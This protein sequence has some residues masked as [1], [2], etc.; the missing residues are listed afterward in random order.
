MTLGPAFDE[1][2]RQINKE[3]AFAGST[4]EQKIANDVAAADALV[5]LSREFGE[6]LAAE[7]APDLTPAQQEAIY[8]HVWCNDTGDS[9]TEL[10]Q[11]YIT[12]TDF[13]STY[14]TD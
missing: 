7:Y 3:L 4:P 11:A 13:L 5:V 6:A 9:F 8:E 14:P 2:S 10:E 1:R 12:L